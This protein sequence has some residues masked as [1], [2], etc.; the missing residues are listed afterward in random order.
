MPV[1][2][3]RKGKENVERKMDWRDGEVEGRNERRKAKKNWL[4]DGKMERREGWRQADRQAEKL[5]K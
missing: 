1:S 2:Q 3:S 4:K 5:T